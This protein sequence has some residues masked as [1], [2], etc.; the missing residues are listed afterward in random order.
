MRFMRKGLNVLENILTY[1]AIGS[2]F[3]MMCLTTADALGRYLLNA[4]IPVAYDLTEKY[5][6]PMTMALALGFA[7]RSGTFI[8]VTILAER[9]TSAVKIIVDYVVQ[10]ITVLYSIA[11]VGA[12]IKRMFQAKSS[13][14]NL[15]TVDI[16]IWPAYLIIPVALFVMTLW[17]MFDI[18]E[19]KKGRSCLF[20]GEE[21][22]LS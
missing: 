8:R 5:L 3:T 7:Y 21:T 6:L 22:P 17:M 14:M 15:A 11:L 18:A 10:I 16:P 9:L 19:V 20:K 12:T 4:P 1:T 2:A 13:G